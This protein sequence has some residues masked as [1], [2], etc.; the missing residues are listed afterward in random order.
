MST[1]CTAW[2][3]KNTKAEWSE[4]CGTNLTVRLFWFS[5][6]ESSDS[7]HHACFYPDKRAP[8]CVMWS[9]S[10]SY[11]PLE[12]TDAPSSLLS[13]LS[14]A[15]QFVGS[16]VSAGT[17]SLRLSDSSSEKTQKKKRN[18]ERKTEPTTKRKQY[19]WLQH[20]M[21]FQEEEQLYMTFI[22]THL[23]STV[24]QAFYSFGLS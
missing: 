2:I 3:C 15:L 7:L 4:S 21:S 12:D 22:S 17:S 1:G 8:W 24:C 5:L 13:L 16:L 14:V 6:W 10:S 19:L 11:A 20:V 23:K 18:Y 9:A